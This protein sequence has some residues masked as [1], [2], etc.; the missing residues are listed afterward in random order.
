[1]FRKTD[2]PSVAFDQYLAH[3]PPEITDELLAT[4]AEL[5][6]LNIVHINS[7]ATGGGVAEILQSL[8]P[9]T[10]GLGIRTKREVISAT[11]EFFQV[12]KRIHN[13]LQGADGDLSSEESACQLFPG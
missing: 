2:Y 1:M 3:L 9:L 10:N 4:A 7:T 8:V 12:T 13:L 6:H 5:R 11:P